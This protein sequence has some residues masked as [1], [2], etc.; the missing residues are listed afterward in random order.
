M[1]INKNSAVRKKLLSNT[2]R[3]VIKLGTAVLTGQDNLLDRP[4]I[5]RLAFQICKLLNQKFEIILV[6]SGAIGAGMGLLHI[7]SRPVL[8]PSLQATAAIGQG[9]LMKVYDSFFKLKG[10]LTA[11]IL[12]TSEDLNNRQRYLNARNTVF[13]LLK[14]KALPVINENDTVS[15]DEIKFGD[16]DTLAGLVAALVDADLLITLSNIDGL[17]MSDK[18]KNKVLSIIEKITPEIESKAR[19]SSAVGVGGMRTKLQAAK[20]ITKSGISM[21]IANGRTKNIL[22][23]IINGDDIGTMFSPV[24]AK[25]AARKRWI[26]YSAVSKGEIGVDCGARQALTKKGKS[27]LASGI[28][29][30]TGNFKTGDVIRILDDQGRLFARGMTNYSMDELSKIKGFKTSEIKSILGYKYY[31]EVIHRDN[32]VIL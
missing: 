26:A 11:Q 10:Y 18:N 30:A 31:D 29:D 1:V 25:M 21:I 8:L 15:V 27:L 23:R 28:M 19:G 2:K 17:Y 7:K 12:L 6:S 22:I 13:T 14:Y 32:L 3:I 4:Q 5:K 16:N 20:T 9:Q 24:K